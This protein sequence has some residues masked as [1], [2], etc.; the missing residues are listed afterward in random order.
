MGMVHSMNGDEEEDVYDIGGKA[1]RK[2]TP[3]QI[4]M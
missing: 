2:Q 1:K 3:R 4:K